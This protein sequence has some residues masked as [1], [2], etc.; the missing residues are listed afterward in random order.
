MELDTG[1]R[2]KEAKKR[3]KIKMELG[4]LNDSTRQK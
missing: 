1:R 3:E 2:G 4:S